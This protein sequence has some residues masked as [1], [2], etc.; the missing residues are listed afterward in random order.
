MIL[1]VSF[2]S[3]LVLE[4]IS[5]ERQAFKTYDNYNQGDRVYGRES[6]LTDYAV[7]SNDLE[8]NLPFAFTI[9]TSYFIQF[10]TGDK[11]FVHLNQR[12]GTHWI[13]YQVGV[14]KNLDDFTERVTLIYDDKYHNYYSSGLP[15]M[16]HTWYHGCISIDTMNG[17]VQLVI[18]GYVVVDEIIEYFKDSK[19]GKPDSLAGRLLMFKTWRLGLVFYQ[20]R[21]I[22]SN[23]NV[24]KSEISLQ[25]MNEITN[26]TKCGIKGDYLSWDQMTWNVTGI[27]TVGEVKKEELCKFPS[28]SLVLFTANAAKWVECM[29]F[30][31]KLNGARA[32]EVE[33]SYQVDGLLNWIENVCINPETKNY[34][35]GILAPAFWVPVSDEEEE[36]RWKNYY[37]KEIMK[38]GT[39]RTDGGPLENCALLALA[40]KGWNDWTCEVKTDSPIQCACEHPKQIYLRMRG[41]CKSSYIDEYYVP[42]NKPNHGATVYNGFRSTVIERSIEESVW[43]LKINEMAVANT[44][45]ESRASYKSFILGTHKWTISN[46]NSDCNS[47]APYTA[48]LKLTGCEEHEFT[49]TDGQCIRHLQSFFVICF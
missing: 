18:N 27:V 38:E 12:D 33:H 28:T 30:C 1:L 6:S 24:F 4:T 9:C 40:W 5:I 41:R 22:I 48:M 21:G 2:I 31:P 11:N 26:G 25:V 35:P 3:F 14:V 43:K 13:A 32:P 42:G 45:A 37:T 36:G 47:G 46:D 7:L 23:M 44:T 20:S 10:T 49:C 16:P 34:Q 8:G 15:I 19:S 17:H 39:D 29:H